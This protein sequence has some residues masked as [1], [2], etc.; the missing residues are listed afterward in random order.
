MTHRLELLALCPLRSGWFQTLET[1]CDDGRLSVGFHGCAT[2]RQARSQLESTHR[3]S[4]LLVDARTPGLDRHLLADARAR[5]CPTVV[6]GGSGPV[7]G[8]AR[9]PRVFSARELLG[10]LSGIARP[11]R[12]RDATPPVPAPERTPES[13][14]RGRLV[15]VYGPGGTGASTV[16][17][18]LAQSFGRSDRAGVVL[19]DAAEDPDLA[20]FHGAARP[21]ATVDDLVAAHRG[22]PVPVATVR[23][24]TAGVA[25]RGYRLLHAPTTPRGWRRFDDDVT[26]AVVDDLRRAFD[27]VVVDT[28]PS[29]GTPLP[30]PVDGVRVVVVVVGPGLKGLHDLA[31]CTGRLAG[32]GVVGDRVVPVVNRMP[33][34]PAA[35][36]EFTAAAARLV[37]TVR[38]P[39]VYLG[40]HPDLEAAHRD[41]AALPGALSAPVGNVVARIVDPAVGARG[42]SGDRTRRC[43][44]RPAPPQPK[45]RRLLTRGRETPVQPGPVS[46]HLT[47]GPGR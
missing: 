34:D 19:V 47:I 41:I 45:R 28:G 43:P 35:R 31:R 6:I 27:M 17:I 9:L 3:F 30:G 23:A 38:Q 42:G 32:V 1:W 10:T 11:V 8:T 44:P 33:R 25:S 18:G 46:G 4:A 13:T 15:A 16:A 5:H 12:V 40:D 7:A 2:T 14:R 36:A 20:L 37:P 29:L 22:G 24:V 26:R 21:D 39:P